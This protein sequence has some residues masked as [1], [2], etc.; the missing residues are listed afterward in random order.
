MTIQEFDLPARWRTLLL[1]NYSEAIHTIEVQWPDLK[2]L[3]V[4]YRDIESFDPDFARSIIEEPEN[5]TQA[6]NQALRQ[7]VAELGSPKKIPFVRI[8]ELPPDSTRVV[9]NPLSSFATIDDLRRLQQQ[10][11][12]TMFVNALPR[13]SKIPQPQHV[14]FLQITS[15]ATTKNSTI[16]AAITNIVISTICNPI[17]IK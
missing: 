9:R 6:A 17:G 14:I 3:E 11:N 8:I 13:I 4:S 2:S 5:N 1:E 12:F 15:A 7:L 10:K 16:A